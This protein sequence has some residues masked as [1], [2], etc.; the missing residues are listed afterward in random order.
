MS[1]LLLY[2]TYMIVYIVVYRRAVRGFYFFSYSITPITPIKTKEN[3]LIKQ[4]KRLGD[5]KKRRAQTPI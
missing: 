4:K 2:Y 3:D 1:A 5:G